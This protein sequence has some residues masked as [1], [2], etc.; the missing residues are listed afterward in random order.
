M[1]TN[2]FLVHTEYHL[3]MS[4]H[5]AT[6][7]HPQDYKNNLI[8]ITKTQ[9]RFQSAIKIGKIKNITLKVLENISPADL[10]KTLRKIECERFFFFQEDSIYNCCLANYFRKKG[11]IIC[12]GP[13]GY[14]PYAVYKKKH[15][16]LSMIRDT[17]E[18]YKKL[19]QNRIMPTL[20]QGS[21][22]YKYGSSRFIDKI[23]LTHPVYLH[24]QNNPRQLEVIKIPEFTEASI[25]NAGLAFNC[26]QFNF[27]LVDN[28]IYYFNQPFKEKLVVEEF[29]FLEKLIAHFPNNAIYIKLHPLTTQAMKEKYLKLK[30][31]K[32][33]DIK[34]PAE[35]FILSLKNAVLLTGWSTVL[36]TENKSCNYYFN[37]PI[38]KNKGSKA[39][40]QSELTILPHIKL[41]SSPWEIE[42][43]K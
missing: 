4:I 38:Y 6:T 27:P 20:F 2:L 17:I 16:L 36:I 1:S 23:Y 42:F 34:V 18:D 11:V 12:L 21:W 22:H 40:D 14:K 5:I 15:E 31:V 37:L 39:T 30:D 32:L 3:L 8:Y 35:L 33:I 29:F 43:P 13:D 19:C 28:A 24:E 41:I 10:I 9:D 26:N 7:M 25:A